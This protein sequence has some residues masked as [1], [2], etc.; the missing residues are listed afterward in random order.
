[1]YLSAKT[2]CISK[3]YGSVTLCCD[4]R[5]RCYVFINRR[6]HPVNCRPHRTTLRTPTTADRIIPRDSCHPVDQNFAAV[7]YFSNRI[8]TYK[9]I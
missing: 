6:V 9:H 2:I 4:R 3:Q 1:M 7:G 8:H 5:T